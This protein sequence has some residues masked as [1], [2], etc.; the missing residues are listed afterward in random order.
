[1]R[2]LIKGGHLIDPGNQK[3]GKFDLLINKGRIE[4]V[5][6]CG[7]PVGKHTSLS[8]LGY[9]ISIEE[10]QNSLLENMPKVLGRSTGKITTLE[11]L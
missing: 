7:L 9:Q 5:E 4:A 6:G 11:I 2:T 8:K 1:M 3:N 10:M